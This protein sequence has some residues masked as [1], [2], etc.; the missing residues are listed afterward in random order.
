[1]IGKISGIGND[2]SFNA[3]T[4]LLARLSIGFCFPFISVRF[5]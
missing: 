4:E 3:P 5:F 2:G 1:M